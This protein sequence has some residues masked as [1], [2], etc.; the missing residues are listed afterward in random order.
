MRYM[1]LF[2]GVAAS[3]LLA[4]PALAGI[5]G[6]ETFKIADSTIDFAGNQGENGWLYGYYDADVPNAF[7]PDDFELMNDYDSTAQRWWASQDST[8]TLIDANFMHSYVVNG[9][10]GNTNEQWAVRR[11]VNDASGMLEINIDMAR[12]ADNMLG[13]GVRLHVYIDGVRRLVAD[14]LPGNS[15]GLSFMLYEDVREGAVIDFALDGGDNALF[16]G[17]EFH[18]EIMRVVPSPAS[19][20]LLGLGGLVAVRRRR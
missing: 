19:F 12:G 7:T 1:S 10:E 9:P 14:L 13:D 5:V 18:A 11:W 2:A 8:L 15:A 17:T 16:D 3:A 4:A 20:A 6:P